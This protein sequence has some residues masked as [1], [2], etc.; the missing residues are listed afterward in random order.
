MRA[1]PRP[2]H[3]R[4][5]GVGRDLLRAR[6]RLRGRAGA[7]PP[8]RRPGAHARAPLTTMA[9]EVIGEH[10]GF[11]RY[12]IGQ[13]RGLP[14]GFAEPMYVVAIRPETPRGGR[15]PGGDARGEPASTLAEV[16]WLAAPLARRRPLRRA[17]PVPVARHPGHGHRAGATTASRSLLD[18]PVARHLAGP[19]GRAVRRRRPGAGRRGDRVNRPSSSPRSPSALIAG[20]GSAAAQSARAPMTIESFLAV[21]A[22]SDPQPSPDGRLLAFTVSVPSLEE[23]RNRSRIWLADLGSG[24]TWEATSGSGS[25]RSPRWSADGRT[26]SYISTREEGAQ[27]WRL[28]IRGGEPTRL[29]AVPGGISEFWVSPGGKA[30]FY[31]KDVK[32]PAP[33]G[34]RPPPR[35]VPHRGEALDG[36]VLPALERMAGGAPP[37]PVPAGAGGLDRHRRDALRP[38]RADPGAR[39]RRRGAVAVRDRGGGGAEPRFVAGHQHQ[40]RHLRDGARRQRPAGH[41]EQPG[42]RQF[43]RLLPGQPLRRVPGHDGPRIRG[44]PPAGDA[45][46]AGDRPAAV[47]HR[48]LDVERGRHQLDSRLARAHRGGA[49][50]RR[51]V[52]LPDRGDQRAALAARLGRGQPRGA[53]PAARR[54]DGVRP[55][56][57]RPPRRG[58]GRQLDDRRRAPPG[59]EAERGVAGGRG[60]HAARAV[61]LRG[62]A[63]RLGLRVGHEAAGLRSREEVPGGLPHPRRPAVGVERRVAPALELRDV[64]RARATWWRP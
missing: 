38:R 60:A 28:P 23:D 58:V 43:P 1:A 14:G 55:E 3:R 34:A 26:L 63:G 17:D 2:G 19:V 30:L 53:R 32:W 36:A 42:Q 46:R 52:A 6:R 56:H 49:G 9:G 35:R 57:G 41:H 5:A 40:Q 54:R 61:R 12:T 22:V 4:Q 20:A 39:R 47:A 24:E 33:D 37:A 21:R 50:A 7:A 27:I 16:N 51:R 29:T 64:R 59:D 11:A 62:G 48:R 44:G 18:T 25:E 31:V 15:R 45:L 13:R 10:E 8:R